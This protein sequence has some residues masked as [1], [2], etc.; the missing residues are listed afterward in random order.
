MNDKRIEIETLQIMFQ[1]VSRVVLY[2]YRGFLIYG[3]PSPPPT[4]WC[5]GTYSNGLPDLRQAIRTR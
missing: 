3:E 5:L 1:N 4:A 2:F